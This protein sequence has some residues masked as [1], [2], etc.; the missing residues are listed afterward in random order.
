MLSKMRVR[1]HSWGRVVLKSL[2]RYFSKGELLLWAVS[3]GLILLS[4]LFFDRENVLVLWWGRF[5]CFS[6]PRATLSD[7]F[8]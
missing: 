7:S 4:F 1:I 8:A 3:S 2:R 6:M 5:L